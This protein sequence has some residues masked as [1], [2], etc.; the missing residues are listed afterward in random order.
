MD[1]SLTRLCETWEKEASH[2]ENQA[3]RLAA[4]GAK[5]SAAYDKGFAAGLRFAEDSLE[6]WTGVDNDRPAN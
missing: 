4:V 2:L 5:Q 6:Y 3:D 1:Q